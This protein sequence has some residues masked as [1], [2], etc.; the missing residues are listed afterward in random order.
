[1]RNAKG[2]LVLLIALLAG[3]LLGGS[4]AVFYYEQQFKTQVGQKPPHLHSPRQK[5]ERL[6]RI[7][8]L[9]PAQTERLVDIITRHEPEV[10]A[11]HARTKSA[12]D[13][14]LDQV[15]RELAPILTPEQN[16][17]FE[18]FLRDIKSRPFPPRKDRS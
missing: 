18:E 17:K 14:V 4:A 1:M 11:V 9:D 15:G 10:D 7:L 16:A 5:A 6:A 2:V 3:A 12:L 8:G 13:A